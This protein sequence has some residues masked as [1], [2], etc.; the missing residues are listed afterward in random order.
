MD[1]DPSRGMLDVLLH[2]HYSYSVR[3]VLICIIQMLLSYTKKINLGCKK[4]QSSSVPSPQRANK[5]VKLCFPSSCCFC[6]N[7]CESVSLEKRFQLSH[8]GARL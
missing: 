5:D 2:V 4:H 3:A 6:S 7:V 8:F 1:A